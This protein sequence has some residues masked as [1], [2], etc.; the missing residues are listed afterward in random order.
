MG[1]HSLIF[2][3]ELVIKHYILSTTVF[4]LLDPKMDTMESAA[5]YKNKIVPKHLPEEAFNFRNAF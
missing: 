5:V 3:E 4:L 1:I 2:Q